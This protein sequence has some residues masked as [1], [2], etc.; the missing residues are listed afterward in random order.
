[1]LDSLTPTEI[2]QTTLALARRELALEKRRV[3]L[4]RDNAIFY[5]APHEK[6]TLFFENAS[7]RYRY[8]R[9]GNRFGKSEMGACEDVAYALGYRPWY[10]KDDPRR[11]LGIPKHATKG[12]I[13]CTT[14]K[15]TQEVF[16]STES[17]ANVGKLF[18][19][20]PASCLGQVHQNHG[21]FI[22]RVAVRHT[23]GDW[24]VIHLDTIEGFKKNELSQESSV[25]DWA[26]IDEPIPE[27]MWK[28]I[29]RGL[30]DRGG[31][32]W[33]TCTP[34]TEPWIDD[35]FCPD[36]QADRGMEAITFTSGDRFMMTGTMFDNPHNSQ[37]DI[38]SFMSWLT[39]DEAE[40]RKYGIPASFAGLVYK[41]FS[42]NTHVLHTG[43]PPRWKDWSI[44]PSD[45]TIRASIDYHF[46]KNDAVLFSATSPEEITYIFAELWDQMMIPDEVKAIKQILGLHIPQSILVDP[47][48]STP[49]K[50]TDLTAME[51]Y[52]RHGLPVIPATKD[53]VN[54]IRTVKAMLKSRTKYDKPIIIFNPEL[55]RTLFEISRGFI[56]DGDNNKPFKK[57]DD[58]MEN[59]YRLAQQDGFSYV[60]PANS[61]SYTPIYVPDL[62][63]NVLEIP[64]FQFSGVNTDL[65]PQ[66]KKRNAQRYRA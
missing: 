61:Q 64:D 15:K 42:W 35:A 50:M 9:T 6:Q 11:T 33:F 58:M 38:D 10:P 41:E 53:P 66:H 52:Y 39:E 14:W 40:C 3:Q 24:S 56:W 65:D 5:F 55:K 21:G 27:K 37:E 1:M 23:S 30:V 51:E 47:L 29:A 36:M 59:L 17:G 25:W 22:D 45:H 34:L 31:R 54:G 46:R 43:F 13:V 26:H 60:E 19:Y 20:I 28:A 7:F 2:N 16:T 12:L 62:P 44:P 49:N 63:D 57:N 8:A 18:K 4:E 48:A 32:S